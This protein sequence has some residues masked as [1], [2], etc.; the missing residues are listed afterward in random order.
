MAGRFP[1]TAPIPTVHPGPGRF[2]DPP[3]APGTVSFTRRP[4]SG[5]MTIDALDG[6]AERGGGAPAVG[7]GTAADDACPAASG[8]C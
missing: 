2:P 8:R 4:V 5:T 7:A 3:P 6:P 1:D